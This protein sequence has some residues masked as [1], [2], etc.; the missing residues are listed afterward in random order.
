[1]PGPGRSTLTAA[2][3][4]GRQRAGQRNDL[5]PVGGGEHPPGPDT[6][7]TYGRDHL[8]P[9]HRVN[10]VWV[11]CL[12]PCRPAGRWGATAA[13]MSRPGGHFRYRA[14]AVD[15]DVDVPAD[16]SVPLPDLPIT[17]PVDLIQMTWDIY[18]GLRRQRLNPQRRFGHAKEMARASCH[19]E[20]ARYAGSFGSAPGI[21]AGRP[22]AGSIYERGSRCARPRSVACPVNGALRQ[23]CS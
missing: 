20:Q 3:G 10:G 5:G 17:R 8:G 4:L 22:T 23:E 14:T 2:P 19:R 13:A 9:I 7:R 18:V 16:G 1:V 15:V 6:R 12:E 21:K 11:P